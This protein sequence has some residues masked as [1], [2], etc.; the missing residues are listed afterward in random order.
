MPDRLEYLKAIFYSILLGKTEL[1][2]LFYFYGFGGSGKS[3]VG[4]LLSY[5]IGDDGTYS[6]SL[7]ALKTDQFEIANLIGKKLVIINDCA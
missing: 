6:T 2:V 1:Q 4:E 3:T 5:F 7:K